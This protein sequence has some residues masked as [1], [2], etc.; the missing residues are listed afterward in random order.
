[1]P[2]GICGSTPKSQQIL[3]GSGGHAGSGGASLSWLGECWH[4]A[5]VLY[6]TVVLSRPLEN[7]Q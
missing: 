3:S 1:M 2:A 5:E 7:E 6:C 4:Y